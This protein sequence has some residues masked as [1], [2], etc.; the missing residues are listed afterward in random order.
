[1]FWRHLPLAGIV[2]IVVIGCGVRPWLQYRRYGSSGILLFQ[3]GK[4]SQNLR[5]AGLVVV[6]TLLIAQASSLAT[7]RR[8]RDL[9]IAVPEAMH[10]QLQV[11]GAVLMLCG[12]AFFAAAQLNMGASWRI[13]IKEGESPGL[14]TAGFHRLCRH[15]IYLGLLIAV[16][17]YTALLPTPLSLLLLAAAY[18]GVRLQ[19]A[20]EEAHL[21]R[22]YGATYREYA[23][24][25]GRLLP[26]VGR[27]R[28]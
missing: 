12:I 9:P 18:V 23:R 14:V 2:A 27:L 6:V 25:I 1:M 17:G 10:S 15:P 21:E 8:A 24:R 4:R 22:T 5:D 28:G 26:G 11:A 19:A 20:A 3:S 13:G 7:S 16:A